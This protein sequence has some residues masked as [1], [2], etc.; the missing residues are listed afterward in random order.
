MK[1]CRDGLLLALAVPLLAAS[2]SLSQESKDRLLVDASATG[3][4]ISPYIY[5]QFIEHLGRCIYGGL[6]AEMLEDRKFFYPV[7]GEAPAWEMF[8]PGPTLV[9]RRGPSLRAA[10]ALALDD[11]RREGRRHH[12]ARGA[13][14]G[15]HSPKLALPGGEKPLGLMQ[16][17]LGL[18]AGREYVGRVV[19]RAEGGAGPVEVSLAWGGGASDRQTVTIDERRHAASPSTRLRF[20]CGGTTDNGRLEIVSRGTG[21]LV[22][23]HGLADARRQRARLARRHARAAPRARLPRLP[24]AGRQLRERLRLAGR[25]SATATAGRRGRT[26]RGRASSR[27]TSASTS[28]WS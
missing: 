24:L 28:S 14:A 16:E 9:G 20:R 7:T 6:W 2:T 8:K 23:R 27:T 12:A 10:R 5:G 3:A 25:R 19:L 26:R 15:E 11:P 21:A 4:P 1:L 13:Y 22:D 17:R 18:E